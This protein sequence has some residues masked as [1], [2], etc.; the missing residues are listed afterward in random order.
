MHHEDQHRPC[1]F[2]EEKSTRGR[3]TPKAGVV[4]ILPWK[5][6]DRVPA[7]AQLVS[8]LAAVPCYARVYLPAA[9]LT[10]LHQ[11]DSVQVNIDGYEQAVIGTVRHIRSQP[12]FTPFY[13]LNERDRARLMYL[14]DID[15][16]S[17]LNLPAGVA[18]EVHLP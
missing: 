13:A 3:G 5:Q 15:L 4:D 12:A 2:W 16:P 9:A 18:V 6:G 8:L 11:G 7:G 1:W 10:Q 14:T 17:D